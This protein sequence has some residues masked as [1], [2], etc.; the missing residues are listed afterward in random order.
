MKTSAILLLTL[1]SFSIFAQTI[2]KTISGTV[3][4]TQNEILP[5]ATV[6]LL[7]ATDSLMLAKEITNDR[8]KKCR[9]I[10]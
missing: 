7:K 6:K 10:I 3:K 1:F 4:N 5:G 2:S 9:Q 8:L